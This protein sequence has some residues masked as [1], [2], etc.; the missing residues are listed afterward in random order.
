MISHVAEPGLFLD[1][2]RRALKERG[3]LLVMDFNNALA[4]AYRRR[5]RRIWRRVEQGPLGDHP[6]IARPFKEQRRELL[7]AW[8]P[9]AGERELDR[10]TEATRGHYGEE[11]RRAARALRGGG[12]VDPPEF[13][14]RDPV[15]GSA[16]EREFFPHRL[17]SEL[18]RRGFSAGVLPS[19]VFP[20]RS[21][22]LGLLGWGRFYLIRFT[23]PVSLLWTPLLEV[24]AVK[25]DRAD[26]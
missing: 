4:L 16:C 9:D 18:G 23:H 14:Y 26:S 21:G 10:L 15:S 1:E 12:R 7:R 5:R 24:L 3:R 13:P 11:L 22:L 25:T 17:A 2:V 19:H 6:G 20:S 8:F